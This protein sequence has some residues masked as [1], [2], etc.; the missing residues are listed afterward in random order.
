MVVHKCQICQ[1]VFKQ[2]GHLDNHKKRKSP[3][4]KLDTTA[5]VTNRVL[6]SSIETKPLS[7]YAEK[8]P[9]IFR[10]VTR[11][12]HENV[13]RGE[14]NIII[15]AQVKT[16]KR[17]IAQ[18]YSAFTTPIA[19]EKT[20]HVF[21]SSWVRRDDD[22]QR[23]QLDAYFQGSKA[24]PRV[25]KINNEKSRLRCI[26]K[27][28][29]IILT[30][31][32]TMVHLDELD[33]GSGSEQHMAAV[34]E[35]CM[36]Q[37]KITLIAYSASHEEAVIEPMILNSDR[38]KPVVLPFMP[39]VEYRGA[40]WY[41]DNNLLYDAKP[42]FDISGDDISVS[43]TG[44]GVLERAKARLDS[45]DPRVSRRK[46]L[47]IRQN[48]SFNTIKDLVDENKIPELCGDDEIRIL[49]H[50][51]HSSR[52]LN[53]MTVKWDNYAW[54]KKQIEVERGGGKFLLILFIDQSS[55]RSTDWFCHP[56]LSAY[57]D[58]HPPETPVNTCIQSNLRVVF[59]TNKMCEG[60]KVYQD[61]EFFPEL[62]AQK[63]V[64]EY[65]AGL[66]GLADIKRPVSSRTRVFEQ[67]KT[68]GPVM[69]IRLTSEELDKLP[70][71]RV[72]TDETTQT[73]THAILNK[74]NT[75]ERRI[76]EIRTLK[77]KRTFKKD[78]THIGS[79]RNIASKKLKNI[80]SGPGSGVQDQDYD[81][82]GNYFW[83]EFA[84][85]DIP[86]TDDVGCSDIIP[87][88][89][90]YITHGIADPVLDECD[91]LSTGSSGGKTHRV[92]IK[93]MYAPKLT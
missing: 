58:Y 17:F 85:E 65:V 12:L 84:R 45:E 49:P 68:F 30:H 21:I 19:G 56:W 8:M 87:K 10:F 2:K 16:G 81:N 11:N 52:D 71:D 35:Y 72:L 73:I 34:Y 38:N 74:L 54:W 88:G 18:A 14:K 48:T 46:L 31:D 64:I 44:R 66:K 79:I 61:E 32:R 93:S 43:E 24:D 89:T 51:I 86:M 7:W 62:H 50:F 59:Y 53:T 57:H 83:L 42:F 6:T 27:L 41:C 47:I 55:T 36:S 91:D 28:K 3:C 13:S 67:L 37:K 29:K 9:E 26:D 60:V 92:T 40:K 23:K 75:A 20:A 5:I 1:T 78:S 4:K 15:P 76:I 33:Y 82:R 69:K 77:G 22:N 63:E 39:P 90:V 70:L 80:N 25:F